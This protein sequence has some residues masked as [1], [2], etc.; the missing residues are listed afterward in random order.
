MIICFCWDIY[1]STGWSFHRKTKACM[2]AQRRYVSLCGRRKGSGII[3]DRQVAVEHQIT[4][5]TQLMKRTKRL[6]KDIF[7]RG[8]K[9]QHFFPPGSES[10]YSCLPVNPT[11]C[12]LC[13]YHSTETR[14][15]TPNGTQLLLQQPHC[16]QW[17]CCWCSTNNSTGAKCWE[18]R[19]PLISFSNFTLCL[20][21]LCKLEGL[22]ILEGKKS[23]GKEM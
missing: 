23:K 15:S 13:L 9:N 20:F 10:N 7:Q 12:L 21:T 2:T 6:K 1:A 11:G 18:K 22:S 3:L 16:W 17:P 4:M 8:G 14:V 19:V 5:E